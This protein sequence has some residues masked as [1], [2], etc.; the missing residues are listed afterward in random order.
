MT[1]EFNTPPTWRIPDSIVFGLH[2]MQDHTQ[3]LDPAEDECVRSAAPKRRL[4]FST[5]RHAI[6]QIMTT[7][8]IPPQP[9]TIG[10]D[11]QPIW[12]KPVHGSITH[13]RDLCW[14]ALTRDPEIRS[15]G[16]DIE[17]RDRMHP[18]LW[19]R[20]TTDSERSTRAC[21]TLP[22]GISANDFHS[23]I[24]SAK[25]AFF[26]C[27]YPLTSRWLGFK[28]VELSMSFDSNSVTASITNGQRFPNDDL[29]LSGFFS[30]TEQHV[31]SIFL[32]S[33]NRNTGEPAPLESHL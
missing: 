12:P 15:I 23:V 26:K 17:R 29:S 20:I 16:I 4:E 31:F 30:I 10:A 28:D 8:G 33:S 27:Q 9:V 1:N 22:S 11:D 7:W 19:E 6:R 24:F 25:E 3:T 13:T 32:L 21:D 2:S 18:G 14:V 5:A